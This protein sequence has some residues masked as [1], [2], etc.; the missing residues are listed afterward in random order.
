[1][2]PALHRSLACALLAAVLAVSGCDCRGGTGTGRSFGELFIDYDDGAGRDGTLDFGGVFMGRSSS[3]FLRVQN[4]GAGAITLERLDTL[5]GNGVAVGEGTGALFEVRFTPGDVSGSGERLL[6]VVFSPPTPADPEVAFQDHRAVLQ[7]TATNTK[8]GEGTARIVLLGRGVSSLCELPKVVDFGA[9]ALDDTATADVP[10]QNPTLLETVATAGEVS[11]ADK[12]SFGYAP[13]SPQ[14]PLTL[15]PKTLDRKVTYRF[16]PTEPREYLA[17]AKLQVAAQCPE[18]SVQLRGRGVKQT[19][20]W[21]GPDLTKPEELDFGFLQPTL[22]RELALSFE[23]LGNA[24]ATVSGLK[25]ADAPSDFS[26]VSAADLVVPARGTASVTVAFAPSGLGVRQ[27]QVQFKT[28]VVRQPVG[29]VRL[30]GFAGGPKLQVLPSSAVSFGKVAYFAGGSGFQARKVA[31]LNVGA[32]P[33]GVTDGSANL[34]LGS[35]AE[36]SLYAKLEATGAST[37]PGEFQLTLPPPC[38]APGDPVGCYDPALGLEAT[39]GK[40]LAELSVRLMPQSLGAKEA[41]LTIYSNDPTLPEVRLTVTADAVSLPPCNYAVEPASLDFGLIAPPNQKE[42]AFTVTNLG[43]GSG[44]TCVLSGLA[45]GPGSAAAFDLPGGPVDSK[46]L[47]PGERYTVKVRAW[48]KAITGANPLITGSVEL[49]LSS[50]IK[51]QAVLPLRA[52]VGQ[53]CL[54]LAPDDVDFGTVAKGCGSATRTFSLY[55]TCPQPVRLLSIDV[56]AGAGPRPG[57]PDCPGTSP[58]PEFFALADPIPTGGLEIVNGAS[59]PTTF[60]GRYKPLDLGA[61]TGAISVTVLQNGATVSYVV[62][63]AGRGDAAG[64]NTDLFKQD[65][66]P[67]A[68]LLLVIDN[69]C[70]MNDEQASLAANFSSFIQYAS[71][72]Q[73]DWQIGV[74]TTDNE[75]GGEQGRL[76]GDGSNPKILTPNTPDVANKFKVKVNLGTFGSGME[77]GFEPALRALTAPLSGTDNA[78]FVRPE[79][80]LAVLVISDEEEQ[81]PQA[82]SYYLNSFLNIKGFKRANQFTFSAIAGFV[83]P[84]PTGCN[85]TYDVNDR[86]RELVIN[87]GGVRENIC[88]PD[89]A[90][91]LQQLGKTAFGYRS[92]FFLNAVPDLSAGK[93]LA[94]AVDGNAL[95]ELT[96]A[97]VRNWTYDPVANALRFEPAAVP[98]AGQT[99]AITYTVGCLP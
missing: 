1:M 38:L 6:E 99:L 89:W 66:K 14:G 4:L 59:T 2:L 13:G 35:A 58:C 62:T 71:Q 33:A 75:P 90:A 87:S 63:L 82:P 65:L 74:T 50:P 30:K 22:R 7:L 10:V 46:E 52:T 61:D 42:L 85:Y 57:G 96:G 16:T 5:E 47:G 76:V 55:N 41:L 3:R 77:K 39:A 51:P 70:S 91:T 95:P 88:T 18:A 27:S 93:V 37:A 40:N 31:V 98:T 97:G 73:V 44:E 24:D 67:K 79:A 11:G 92:V 56:Q 72:Q 17:F 15:P 49:Y 19:L 28:T 34:K 83:Q 60:R 25:V 54:T 43:G 36:P 94:V 23:N 29:A 84:V 12:A 80:N 9:V 68:D 32:R 78:G 64:Q 8:E 45:I 48:P 21:H 53:A 69:S 26:L 20:V 81:S 86:Y